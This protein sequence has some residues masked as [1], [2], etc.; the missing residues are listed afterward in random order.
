MRARLRTVALA[1]LFAVTV[2]GVL[3]A[4]DPGGGATPSPTG[5]AG[6]SASPTPEPVL[7]AQ[8]D[9][10]YDVDC[11]DLAP[12]AALASIHTAAVAATDRFETALSFGSGGIP[13]AAL[14]L[15]LGGIA[16]EWTNG[17]PMVE[18]H[19]VSSA[20]V[21]TTISVIADAGAEWTKFTDVYGAGDIHLNCYDTGVV[22]NCDLNEFTAGSWI[23]IRSYG[24]NAALGAGTDAYAAAITPLLDAVRA[25]I[26][27]A[28]VVPSS[29]VD[30]PIAS[31]C[32]AV[33]SGEQFGATLGIGTTVSGGP[34]GGWSLDAS[35]RELADA[36]SCIYF[37]PDT[38]LATGMVR[39]L[40][41]A[42]WAAEAGMAVATYP[43]TPSDAGL[44]GAEASWVRCAPSNGEC[45]VDATINGHW[46]QVTV[47][48][49]DTM[50]LPAPADRRAAAVAAMETVI[51]AIAD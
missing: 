6:P 23:E 10:R 2:A 7:G 43:A 12:E 33:M 36:G 38:D 13:T 47:W 22:V 11:D 50:G 46:A 1:C 42:A 30:D 37:Y 31:E 27:G 35:A 14:V 20:F 44:A 8:P 18:N 17:A 34:H 45:T 16:C 5:T 39:W 29:A 32:D 19:Q 3:T 41:G 4:C 51:A 25:A 48:A 24:V 49:D 21:G 40:S 9:S 26:A 28:E 15:Q